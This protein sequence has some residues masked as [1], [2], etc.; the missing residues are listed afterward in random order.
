MSMMKLTDNQFNKLKS[1]LEQL[2]KE[3]HDPL[4]DTT[5]VI[6]PTVSLVNG[7][8]QVSAE[9][10]GYFADYYG[11]FRDGYPWIDPA[12]EKWAENK[13]CYWDWESPGSIVLVTQ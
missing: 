1:Q 4:Y 7:M 12:L 3:D 2:G 9:D 8:L 5:M 13:A 10:G 6:R 11:E